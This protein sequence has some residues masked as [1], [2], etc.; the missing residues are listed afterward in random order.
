MK[1]RL[2]RRTR[3]RGQSLAEFALVLPVF[4]ILLMV[5]L[6]F[7]RVVYAQHTLA[8]DSRE[9]AR[10]GQVSPAYRQ[11]KY[12]GTNG[13]QG[14]R[15]ASRTISPGVGLTNAMIVGCGTADAGA[16]CPAGCAAAALAAGEPTAVDDTVST[17]KCFYPD[18]TQP[19]DRVFVTITVQ[20]PI[21]TPILSNLMGGSFTV[22][23]QSVS[24]IQ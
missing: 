14:I 23:A 19:G 24:Y 1:I 17:T 20:V 3:S 15:R 16:A 6:D 4:L 5:L 10:A 13:V 12:D 8:N 9:G 22:T 11:D 18:G 21:I 2:W 7:G